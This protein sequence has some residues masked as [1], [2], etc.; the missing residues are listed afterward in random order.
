MHGAGD[1]P[2]RRSVTVCSGSD[3]L[4]NCPSR[5][6]VGPRPKYRFCRPKLRGSILVEHRASSRNSF[7]MSDAS[8]Q[9]RSALWSEDLRLLAQSAEGADHMHALGQRK[10]ADAINIS[11]DLASAARQLLP[12]FRE[13]RQIFHSSRV[14]HKALER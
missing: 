2:G 13:A 6:F 5:G 11:V 1:R 14:M 7:K 10:N 4:T 3:Q 9:Q 12:L 8:L